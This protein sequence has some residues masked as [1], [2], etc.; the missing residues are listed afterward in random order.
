MDQ[1]NWLTVLARWTHIGSVIVL[2]GGVVFTRFVLIPAATVAL[3]DEQH[4]KLRSLVVGRWK[5]FV[6]TLIALIFISGIYNVIILAPQR[7]PVWHM[8]FGLK[9][10]L[11]MG[12]FFIASAM[13]GRSK[14]MQG[15]R[16]NPLF[17]L[18]LN[19]GLAAVI[20]MIS[21]VLRSLPPKVEKTEEPAATAL[22]D[23]AERLDGQMLGRFAHTRPGSLAG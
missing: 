22:L 2:V 10:L 23:T 21:G 5:M 18:G 3:S 16:D 4:D 9:F 17:W 11:A 20:V 1:I 15:M 7:T 8:L 12:V 13:V 19:C 6:H 14:G